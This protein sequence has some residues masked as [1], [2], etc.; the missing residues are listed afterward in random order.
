MRLIACLLLLLIS[1]PAKACVYAGNVNVAGLKQADVIFVGTAIG[2]EPVWSSRDPD[3]T[4]HAVVTFRVEEVLRGEVGDTAIVKLSSGI[5]FAAP[6]EWPYPATV[7]V[8]ALYAHTR[9]DLS[10]ERVQDLPRKP[11]DLMRIVSQPCRGNLIL[12][13]DENH[14]RWIKAYLTPDLAD[15][16]DIEFDFVARNLD[17]KPVFSSRF[18]ISPNSQ[19]YPPEPAPAVGSPG[20]HP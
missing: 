5:N 17:F 19:P 15:E 1:Q 12:R 4:A 13:A 3:R 10:G 16:R 7:T 8:A 18:F 14:L 6:A 20:S 2:Y 9:F 11:G